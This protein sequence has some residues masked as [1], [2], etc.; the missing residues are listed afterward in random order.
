MIGYK[1][2]PIKADSNLKKHGV[3][4][5]DVMGVFED[6]F[7]LVQKDPRHDEDRFVIMASDYQEGS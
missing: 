2:D 5:A 3:D 6:E 1:W 4:F 7:A